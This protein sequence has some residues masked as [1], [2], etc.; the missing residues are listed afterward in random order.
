MLS[1]GKQLASERGVEDHFRFLESD[2]NSWS[3]EAGGYDIA[4]AN[5]SLHHFVE[6]EMMF[7]KTH[8][9]LSDEG[10]FLANDMIGRNG[11]MLW[12]EALELV[13]AFWSLLDDKHKWNCQL[14][15]FEP[16][17]QNWNCS[18]E[19]F[20]GIR[21]QDILPLLVKTFHFE[22]FVGFANIITVF[23]DRSF[24]HNFDVNDP[25]DCYFIDV[26]AQIDEYFIES[27]KLKPT[28]MVAAMT[29]S[30]RGEPRYYKGF[31]PQA[32]IRDPAL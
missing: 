19:G 24:G 32:S 14:Q 21:A 10:Y 16:T 28:Q 27:G 7:Q 25:R 4:I 1:R 18:V 23:V 17:F 22:C 6:L 3:P 13:Q 26:V 11:H 20:E 8:E 29:K 30:R 2:I 15:R 9:C 31:S 5:H 12:P